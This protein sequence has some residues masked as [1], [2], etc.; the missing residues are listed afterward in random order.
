M[1]PKNAELFYIRLLLHNIR[2]PFVKHIVKH[3]KDQ[4]TE[5][6]SDDIL[7]KLRRQNPDLEINFNKEVFNKSLILLDY[8]PYLANT[9]PIANTIGSSSISTKSI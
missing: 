8:H 6:M 3:V 5:S 4:Y 1:H 9:K 7:A 2:G